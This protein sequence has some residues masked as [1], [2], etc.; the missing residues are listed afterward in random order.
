[1]SDKPFISWKNKAL[2]VSAMIAA[3]VMGVSSV[4]AVNVVQENKPVDRLETTIAH[5]GL[6]T[7]QVI[8]SDGTR[9]VRGDNS[10]GQLGVENGSLM[11]DDWVTGGNAVPDFV[12]LSGDYTH[13]LGLTKDKKI[14]SW[15]SNASGEIG[16]TINPAYTPQQ[17]KVS[18]P[19]NII[20]AGANYV[21]AIDNAGNL[22]SWGQ[23]ENGQLGTGDKK[24]RTVP[25]QLMAG[26]RWKTVAAGKNFSLAIDEAG[27]L[28][29]WGQN[30][31]GQLGLNDNNERL[32]P[33]LVEGN[34]WASVEA[35]CSCY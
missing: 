9:Y 3:T 34:N 8:T 31:S 15:G 1:M 28:Y 27:N 21:L 20:V 19:Y 18:V 33:T 16:N 17:V 5:A 30:N 32:T 26:T 4:V 14:Y 24:E 6:D 22:L 13:T 2:A 12:K 11:F 25:T 23:N 7:T 29:S 10:D 35:N